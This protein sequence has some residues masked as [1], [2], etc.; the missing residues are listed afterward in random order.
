MKNSMAASTIKRLRPRYAEQPEQ[1]LLEKS[2]F[3]N[4]KVCTDTSLEQE[5]VEKKIQEMFELARLKYHSEYELSPSEDEDSDSNLDTERRHPRLEREHHIAFLKSGLKELS[6]SYQCLDASRTWLCYWILHSLDLLDVLPLPDETVRHIADF[7]KRCQH[8]DGGFGGGP[9]QEPHL[10]STYAA[11]NALCILGDEYAYS[12]L[13]RQGL[14]DFFYKMKQPDGSF[15]LHAGGEIDV[16]GIYLVTSCVALCNLISGQS[17][18]FENTPEWVVSCQTYEG[19]FAG[20]PGLEAHGG[21]S[22]CGLASLCLLRKVSL[23]DTK[24]LL[25]WIVNRQM[26]F[27]GG[28]QGRT[29]KL[30]DGCYSF[31]QAGAIPLLQSSLALD[32]KDSKVSTDLWLF[33]VGA[34]Q[35]YVL[36]SCQHPRGGLRDKPSKPRDYYHTCYCLSG[37]SVA[38]H[39]GSKNVHILGGLDNELKVTHPVFNICGDTVYKALN[40]FKTL[41]VP[42][43]NN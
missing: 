2:R 10:A 15:Q 39:N 6:S 3:N 5:T 16:R 30:V 13:N 33:H 17:V 35:E 4:D 20:R 21:Y 38:Q 32:E 23:C 29:G 36:T 43:T 26:K 14:L 27:E 12:V 37:L 7:L 41:P 1:E 11:V 24:L 28:F 25:R 31:W 19:G 34:L 8:P 18:L 9:G 42:D 22:F 40:Y